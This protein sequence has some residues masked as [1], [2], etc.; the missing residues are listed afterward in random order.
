MFSLHVMLLRLVT[1]TSTCARVY[2]C[3]SV[4]LRGAVS[5][6]AVKANRRE[7]K[8]DLVGTLRDS[9]DTY[10]TAYVFTYENM[11][12]SK[13]KDLRSLHTDSRFFLGKNKVMQKAL[14]ETADDAHRPALNLLSSDLRG[15]VGLLLTNKSEEE[16][17]AM[18]DEFAEVD[19][20]RAGF[21]PKETITVPAGR[22]EE[23]P[24]TMAD[25]LRKLGMPVRLDKGIIVLPEEYAI[26]KAGEA[27]T[28]AQSRLLQIFGHMLAVFRLHLISKWQDGKYT[29]FGYTASAKFVGGDDSDDEEGDM[30]D[31]AE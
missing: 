4:F 26:C 17:K 3:A 9:F 11:R 20:A 12:T 16:V 5:L 14:G 25:T 24:H 30:D 21:V 15:N 13:F 8:R 19:F 18:V 31:D 10:S 23:M 22:M 7:L 28:P 29:N 27:L 6:T 2:A 1:H